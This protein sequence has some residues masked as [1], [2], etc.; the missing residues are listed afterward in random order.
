M[1]A[2]SKMRDPIRSPIK[3]KKVSRRTQTYL[4]ELLCL[5]DVDMLNESD[6]EVVVEDE[7][8]IDS[9]YAK[10]LIGNVIEGLSESDKG[11]ERKIKKKK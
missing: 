10:D 8:E 6:F 9:D 7:P 2:E 4:R 11:S 3:L 1:Y 5:R